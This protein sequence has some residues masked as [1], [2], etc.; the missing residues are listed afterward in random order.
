MVSI[1]HIRQLTCLIIILIYSDLVKAQNDS[2]DIWEM[3]L[4]QLSQLKVSSVSKVSQDYNQLSAATF[5]ITAR[6]IQDRGYFTFEEILCDLP[7]FQFRNIMGFNSYVFQR[8]V[9]NQNNLTLL[10]IDGVQVNELNSG[11]FY[12]GGQ[13]ILSDIDRIEV[14]YGPSSVVY[15]ANAVTGII[16]IIT[17]K[18][19]QE[20]VGASTTIGSFNT[21]S[22]NF[23]LRKANK[24]NT[25]GIS[26]SGQ[27]KQS[28]KADLRL[29]K[30]DN[31]WTDLMDNFEKDFSFNFKAE[32]KNLIFGTNYMYKKSSLAS[33]IK[34][35]G[36]EYKDFGT[37]WNIQFNNSYVKYSAEINKYLSL[38]SIVYN[39]NATVLGNT[40]YYVTDTAQIGYYRP[41][42]L[43]GTE[44]VFNYIPFK[45]ISLT[46]GILFEY[47]SLSS[48]MSWSSSDS[49]IYRP[50]KPEKPEMI[51]NQLLS[52]FLEPLFNL[53]PGFDIS[54]G[55]RYD[56][57][58]VYDRVF[59]PRLAIIYNLTDKHIFRLSYSEAFRAPKPWDYSDGLGNPNLLPEKLVSYEF[60]YRYQPC[61][62]FRLDIATYDNQLENTLIKQF[63]EESF[64]WINFGYI[65]TIGT[66]F[67]VFYLSGKIYPYFNYTYCQSFD[68]TGQKVKEISDH[69][70][71]AGITY[72]MNRFFKMNIRANYVGERKNPT[73]IQATGS[74]IIDPYILFN[75]SITASTQFGMAF[76]ITIKNIF[77]K[78][79]YHSSNWDP[80]R[81]RQAQRSILFTAR[82][83]IN[84]KC[85]Q[86]D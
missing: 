40:V 57:S 74:D 17:K 65:N 27:Y 33:I 35:Y 55:V 61:P 60:A 15:G 8:G 20:C 23:C 48:K 68:E 30:G 42:N 54:G 21:A 18:Y 78:K 71:N 47:E 34:S 53:F 41:N 16:N 3:D 80:D 39:R 5:V 2:I 43:I 59:T 24:S 79:Y 28:D 45:K 10:L 76:Q 25:G 38:Q 31:N 7:G 36:T 4:R 51:Q 86:K 64:R 66:E 32:Y 52:I 56:I 1:V 81:Y 62:K 46:T 77:N 22:G 70:A 58:T 14:V 50:P 49:I 67:S 19:D 82:Y 11:G 63:T 75:G 29:E 26:V 83:T 84:P 85:Q 6:Q 12:T 9:P 73:L 72:A 37:S 13:I 44:H 69:V